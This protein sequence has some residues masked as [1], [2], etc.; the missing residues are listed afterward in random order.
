MY[1]KR[2]LQYKWHNINWL[3]NGYHTGEFYL[4]DLTNSIESEPLLDLGLFLSL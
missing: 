3:H 4:R 1:D 2:N